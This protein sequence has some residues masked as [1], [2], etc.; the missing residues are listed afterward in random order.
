MRLRSLCAAVAV[1]LTMWPHAG[2]AADGPFSAFRLGRNADRW[3]MRLGIAAYDTGVFSG[4][5]L[6][7][8]VIEGEVVAPSPSCLR[9]IGAPRPYIGADI[10]L[11]DNPIDVIYTGLNW[12]T[13]VTRRLYFGFSAGG[14]VA[15]RESVDDG[16]GRSKDLGSQLLFHLQ[17]SAGFDLTEHL[18]TQ[19][20]YNH[21]SNA[22]LADPD[23]GLE[24]IGARLGY[25][26]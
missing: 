22:R 24:S 15:S 5:T 11:S 16:H 12:E 10:A 17:A 26:F 25:R 21:F 13:Y 19:I 3:E 23:N 1:A 6:T 9:V 7:G 4:Q 20:Y 2:A 18:T 14:A 8:A